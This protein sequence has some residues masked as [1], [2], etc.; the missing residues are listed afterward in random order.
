MQ[1]LLR[2]RMQHHAVWVRWSVVPLR[3]SLVLLPQLQ[4]HQQPLVVVVLE[5]DSTVHLVAQVQVLVEVAA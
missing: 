3:Q 4:H 1:L 2:L 5:Q